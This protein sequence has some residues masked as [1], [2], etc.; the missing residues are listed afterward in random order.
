[1]HS[2]KKLICM[3]DFIDSNSHHL[4]L[5]IQGNSVYLF[6][7]SARQYYENMPCP[8]KTKEIPINKY[9]M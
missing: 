3:F 7:A 2:L 8:L 4:D 1:M 5:T 6:H 9:I